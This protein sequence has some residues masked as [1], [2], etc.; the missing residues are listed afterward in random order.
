MRDGDD[1]GQWTRALSYLIVKWPMMRLVV[2]SIVQGS[3]QE[4]DPR[5]V[6]TLESRYNDIGDSA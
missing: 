4:G 1:Y 2:S 6:G 3:S 5:H